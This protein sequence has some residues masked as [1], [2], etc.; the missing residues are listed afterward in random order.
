[1]ADSDRYDVLISIAYTL[2]STRYGYTREQLAQLVD[3]YR[4]EPRRETFERRFERDKA[5]L[6]RLGFVL[7][8]GSGRRLDG[9]EG[10][11][12]APEASFGRERRYRID[13]KDYALPALS[14]TT[15][16]AAL[17]G[18]ASQVVEGGDLGR[19]AARAARRLG[20]A[21]AGEPTTAFSA[22]IDGADPRL[23][24][25][26]RHVVLGTPVSFRYRSADG[27]ESRRVVVPWGVGHRDG[28][29]YLAAGDRSRDDERLFRL[30]RIQG[31][32]AQA[33]TKAEDYVPE[34]YGRTDHFDM[35][36]TLDR[37]RASEPRLRA[38][39]GVPLGASGGTLAARAE[40]REA[41]ATGER[42]VLAYSDPG[43]LV[44]ELAAEG[45]DVLEPQGLAEALDA[46]LRQALS[47]QSA[48]VPE[49]TLRRHA[50]GRLPVEVKVSRSLDLVAHVCA[51][52][53]LQ[54]G[55]RVPLEHLRQRF[56]LSQAELT[57]TLNRLMLCGIPG[58]MHHELLDLQVDAHG[59]RISDAA[60]LAQPMNLSLA[61]A[62]AVLL[63]LDALASAPEGTLGQEALASVHA[64]SDRLKA[65]RPAE[66]GDFDR[67]VAVSVASREG[68]ELVATVAR[69]IADSSAL[70]LVHAGR[71]GIT[72]RRVEPVQLVEE[73]SHTYL[74]AWCRLRQEAR[75]FRLDRVLGA[76]EDPEDTGR[77][78]DHVREALQMPILPEG[79]LEADVAFAG[80]WADRAEAY[81][82]ALQ[83][84]VKG[85]GGLVDGVRT[86]TARIRVTDTDH[87]LTLVEAAG[88]A[89]RVLAPDEVARTVTERLRSRVESSPVP[90]TNA[91]GG[92]R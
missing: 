74:R 25:L 3:D 40:S 31:D 53:D 85:P 83:G 27:R 36:A 54:V 87:L 21:D 30:D 1:M 73:N 69:A 81:R 14:F 77:D 23:S 42:L 11:E 63:G 5:A 44:P 65:L 59:V 62:A 6:R 9:T 92:V 88:G 33:N 89:V 15:M 7:R 24:D 41:T 60:A 71:H 29:W 64:L 91:Q 47:A 80:A 12:P 26:F 18:L 39:L 58:G 22:R 32:L 90:A 17:L 38:V 34:A 51:E 70:D 10:A 55:G 79:W 16:E 52:Q 45:V 46:H 8:D 28:H 75:I 68:S 43:T 50:G 57:D 61:E 84:H 72:T 4:D 35:R 49:Y 66:L 48:P 2:M 37:L 82:P 20:V 86:R 19:Q 76:T 67:V 56:D 13:P 78:P